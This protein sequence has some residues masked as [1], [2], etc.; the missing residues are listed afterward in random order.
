M[1]VTSQSVQRFTSFRV[2]L[3]SLGWYVGREPVVFSVE[4]SKALAD[5]LISS[6]VLPSGDVRKQTC[7]VVFY[8]EDGECVEKIFVYAPAGYSGKKVLSLAF[9]REGMRLW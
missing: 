1:I 6:M 5:E 7:R 9:S 4:D 3:A 8:N 2:F